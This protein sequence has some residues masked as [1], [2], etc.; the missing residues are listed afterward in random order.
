MEG[1]GGTPS[2]RLEQLDLQILMSANRQKTLSVD[3][4][5]CDHCVDVV[6][7]VL[8]ELDGVTVQEIEIG[9]VE[10]THDPTLV[11]ED[12]LASVLDDAGY[13]LAALL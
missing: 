13:E 10:L 4:M 8:A 9:S 12:D 3:G 7:E 11:S 2:L 1:V 5:H 6:Q